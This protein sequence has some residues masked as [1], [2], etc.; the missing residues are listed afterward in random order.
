[1]GLW[2]PLVLG[3]LQVVLVGVANAEGGERQRRAAPTVPGVGD[4]KFHGE[5]SASSSSWSFS[6]ST[7][8][9]TV[10]VMAIA[11]LLWQQ[12]Q[13]Q[14][15]QQQLSPEEAAQAAEEAR[16]KRLSRLEQQTPKDPKT[17]NNKLA[18]KK[19]VPT[20]R[21]Q[22]P[23]KQ[24]Q[25]VIPKKQ[26]QTPQKQLPK[27]QNTKH[28]GT[29]PTQ[30]LKMKRPTS[31]S[32]C[33]SKEKETMP[34]VKIK[35]ESKEQTKK[36]KPAPTSTA[37][38]DKTTPTGK[39]DK[40][41]VTTAKTKSTNSSTTTT[42]ETTNTTNNAKKKK[43]S[44]K[45]NSLLDGSNS[46]TDILLIALSSITSCNIVLDKDA[47]SSTK[48]AKTNSSNNS[49]KPTIALS[50]LSS[51]TW[52]DITTAV[53][54]PSASL[55][56]EPLW[57]RLN[58]GPTK[59]SLYVPTTLRDGT[60]YKAS[61]WYHKSKS[62]WTDH[63]VGLSSNSN[64]DDEL[65]QQVTTVLELIFQKWIL[66]QLAQQLKVD[67]CNHH[68]ARQQQQ[69][70]QQGSS[71]SLVDDDVDLGLFADE[72][73]GGGTTTATTTR[74]NQTKAKKEKPGEENLV[75]EV[76]A[77]LENPVAC[78]KVLT[79]PFLAHLIQTYDN[80]DDNNND[81]P[82]AVLLL[83]EC[84]LRLPTPE[85]S[86][87]LDWDDTHGQI[88]ALV[89]LLMLVS[90]QETSK[91]LSESSSTQDQVAT[92]GK[93]LEE[94]CFM[95]SLF[96]LA[97]FTVPRFNGNVP[98]SGPPYN[99]LL[100][101]AF[102]AAMV[103]IGREYP[104]CLYS[105]KGY[106]A[107]LASFHGTMKHSRSIMKAA[108][109]AGALVLKR[110]AASKTD[111]SNSLLEWIRCLVQA[112]EPLVDMLQSDLLSPDS[113]QALC[114]SRPFLMG[115]TTSLLQ[116][117]TTNLT[118]RML[119]MNS[120]SAFD[121]RYLRKEDDKD[122]SSSNQKW[123]LVIARVERSL[124]DQPRQNPKV[125]GAPERFSGATEF[126]FL[127]AAL[128]R[129]SLF[130]GFRVSEEFQS[131]L[132]NVFAAL[133]NL[134]SQHPSVEQLRGL[135][136][137]VMEQFQKCSSVVHGWSAVVDDPDTSALITSF[138]LMQLQWVATAVD[139]ED[140]LGRIPEWF[141]KL[142][143]QWL[144]HVAV[145]TPNLFSPH[146]GE[147]AVKYATQILQAGTTKTSLDTSKKRFSPPVLCQLIRIAGAFIRE[148]V[149]RARA[150]EK[151]KPHRRGRSMRN[152]RNR[153]TERDD[154]EEEEDFDLDLI[155]DRTLD[156]YHSFDARDLGVTVFTNKFVSEQLGPTLMRAYLAMDAVEGM[157]VEREHHFEKFQVKNE[158]AD[159]LLR[160]WCHPNGESR[161][162]IVQDLDGIAINE[163]SSSIAGALGFL[164]DQ[165][166]Q[167]ILDI[168][169]VRAAHEERFLRAREIPPLSRRDE[170]S[171][172]HHAKFLSFSTYQCRR[173]FMIL[174][175]F[176]QEAK[177]AAILGGD[178]GQSEKIGKL[179]APDLAA[180]FVNLMDRL[181]D[182]DGGIHP[183]LEMRQLPAEERSAG[184]LDRLDHVPPDQL[185]EVLHYFVYSRR[186]ALLEYGLDVSIVTHQL[187]ALAARWHLAA[188]S[189]SKGGART[190]KFLSVVAENDLCNIRKLRNV[191]KRL[192]ATPRE[193]SG[194]EVDNAA[195]ILAR[196]GHIDLSIWKS[197]YKIVGTGPD[198]G[199][200]RRQTAKQDRMSHEELE[201]LADAKDIQAFLDDLE[202]ALA[203]K[204]TTVV[205]ATWGDASMDKLEAKLLGEGEPLKDD[206]YDEFLGEWVV[207][208]ESFL[209]KA[210]N[211][212]FSHSYDSIVRGRS[213]E[214]TVS[215]KVMIKEARK[216]RRLLPAPH[217]NTSVFVCF[218]EERMD[219]SKAI[220]T[221]A[222]DTPFALG[223]F[224]FDI[225]FP[226]HYPGSPPL[227]NF[228]TTG[229]GQTRIS[230]N[231]YNDGKV[232][233]SIL[234][235]YQA[236]DDSQRWNPSTSSL[237]QVLASIQTQLLGDAEPYF[238]DGFGHD[239]QRGTPAG[240]EGS[241]RFNNKIRLHTLRH[242]M[243]AHLRH[244]PLG[245]EEV[246][247]R[248][249][250][251]CRK[252]I[253]V[254][255]RRWTMEA[256]GTPLFQSFVRAYEELL[257]LLTADDLVNHKLPSQEES[258]AWG[259]VPLNALDL[260]SLETC[261]RSFLQLHQA[262]LNAMPGESL[263][264]SEESLLV[265]AVL[266]PAVPETNA[267]EAT[268]N[269][270]TTPTNAQQ[271]EETFNPWAAGGLEQG[272]ASHQST[273][274]ADGGD[275]DDDFDAL[276]S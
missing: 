85:H 255:A 244:P 234:G 72:S 115:I 78:T 68:L 80:N 172:D 258:T 142:P 64:S 157:D 98:R 23:K 50:G 144:A 38:N 201:D 143:S 141:V 247:K 249:F 193:M 30:V 268:S 55:T 93:Q 158:V 188:A 166:C 105:R 184:V 192:I 168:R 97:A 127:T 54:S 264:Q 154:E 62:W 8:A 90:S 35:N 151:G 213:V 48:N 253:L 40:A 224:E 241:K 240:E 75:D 169:D 12:H 223:M 206:A 87:A 229:N 58:A 159:L 215:G 116:M 41:D 202:H 13:D 181:T 73:Y 60:L 111:S 94:Q 110:M 205:A 145:Y 238:S 262:S 137:D 96:Y 2:L 228:R 254:Q 63:V 138:S 17:T 149:R 272:N 191:A 109:T 196:D 113:A 167:F 164:L 27:T 3:V 246:T 22:T 220:I 39:H 161:K 174:Y 129:I 225:L 66:Q 190:S 226:T 133:Q 236:W 81:K 16:R 274:E 108:R 257:T 128:L 175:K 53:S 276:Y 148:G 209:S 56:L 69:Q 67:M 140:A 256:Q 86:T 5:T 227:F 139:D 51:N 250:V 11:F 185:K 212:S 248:H 114:A 88:T 176:T 150:R 182:E 232:C 217:P 91:V 171:V 194:T 269:S 270:T 43:A 44:K 275:E 102:H 57:A 42:S 203:N 122:N 266:P 65:R 173:L 252:R 103:S 47:D 245:F 82:L 231:L 126:F 260:R 99:L 112:N 107:S 79:K 136:A 271:V 24:S 100:P 89:N 179:A 237:A 132:R 216:C 263:E 195:Y 10:L 33:H 146:Q 183:E 200:G 211:G 49:D 233:I 71:N 187:L 131:M 36:E 214:A 9:I 239:G 197:S 74:T 84:L 242:A 77:I 45:R 70:E 101:S 219:L 198:K 235:T 267:A 243:I 156:I 207:S 21:E 59:S 117:C 218:A 189:V 28:T 199:R 208:S 37:H 20:K 153:N 31:S 18:A 19:A 222:T 152:F 25:D 119:D 273:S 26:E 32:D 221:G 1:M 251:L 6:F 130:P 123:G 124:I 106:D 155:D 92:D 204:P 34:Q 177:I 261:S 186:F 29:T 118:T 120:A 147:S 61:D 125:D 135:R 180:M 4:L 210:D 7:M 104:V 52:Q 134:A 76:F 162:Y 83:E 265:Q 121:C 230:S 160:L 46:P 15:Q 178:A 14:Q 170:A 163:F 165:A 95:K 259:A